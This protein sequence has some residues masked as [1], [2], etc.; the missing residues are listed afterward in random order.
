MMCGLFFV[1]QKTAYEMRISDWSSDVC[2]SDLTP[3]LARE[4]GEQGIGN[5]RIWSRGVDFTQFGPDRR[6]HPA[7]SNLPRPVPLSVGRVA[8]EKNLD[9]F[10][11]A[12]VQGT[13][14][15]VGDGPALGAMTQRYPVATFLGG[16]DG[17]VLAA[18]YAAEIG[19]AHA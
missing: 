14:V 16:L 11:S 19:R 18:A 7:L 4:L 8:V 13:K 9:A 15:V 12:K 6:P 3:S 1:K 17:E 10:L 5:T 2:S